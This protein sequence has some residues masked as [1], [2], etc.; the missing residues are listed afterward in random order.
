MVKK[1]TLPI[2]FDQLFNN[3]QTSVTP[4]KN[5]NCDPC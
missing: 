5:K 3:G 4:H 1:P 2:K